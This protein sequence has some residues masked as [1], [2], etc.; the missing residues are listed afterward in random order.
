MREGDEEI[1]AIRR[2]RIELV[3]SISTLVMMIGTIASGAWWAATMQSRVAAL[4]DW[5]KQNNKVLERLGSVEVRVESVRTQTMR[6]E[7]KLDRLIDR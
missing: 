4:E 2:W 3:V 5:T 6:I 7:D 1:G